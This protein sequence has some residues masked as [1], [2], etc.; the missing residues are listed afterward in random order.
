MTSLLTCK[1]QE[2]YTKHETQR[3]AGVDVC[4]VYTVGRNG[5]RTVAGQVEGQSK[6]YVPSCSHCPWPS[7]LGQM[8]SSVVFFLWKDPF[9]A[10]GKMPERTAWLHSLAASFTNADFLHRCKVFTEADFHSH[11]CGLQRSTIFLS[12][13]IKIRKGNTFEERYDSLFHMIKSVDL[14]CRSKSCPITSQM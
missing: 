11:S 7:S 8:S 9:Q 2:P 6:H 5:A 4:M 13:Q 1:I 3:K 10:E 12:N 14:A